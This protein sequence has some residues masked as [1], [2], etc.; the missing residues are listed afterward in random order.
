M[1]IVAYRKQ[2][3]PHFGGRALGKFRH[4]P[5]RVLIIII[6]VVVGVALGVG[7][8]AVVVVT[9]VVVLTRSASAATPAVEN[10]PLY[11]S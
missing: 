1:V 9:T 10:R 7:A 2:G 6:V 5:D 3:S 11:Q 8:A 4:Q